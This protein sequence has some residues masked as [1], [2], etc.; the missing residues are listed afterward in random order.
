MRNRGDI[1]FTGIVSNSSGVFV[2]DQRDRISIVVKPGDRAP[3]GGSFDSAGGG[4]T[5]QGGDIAFGAHLA[6]E[7]PFLNSIYVKKAGTGTITSIAHAGEPAPR[8]G[9]FLS[10]YQHFMND[11]GDVPFL[12]LL[13]GNP[14]GI[15]ET[16][17]VYLR[18]GNT[19]TAIARPGD[20][21][22]GGG[23]FVTASFA[24]G[25]NLHL[26]NAN[27]VVFNAKLDTD[28]NHDGIPDTGLYA[29]SHGSLRLIARSGTVI[30]GLGTIAELKMGPST[31][32]PE[33]S[34]VP[35]SGAVNNDRGQV[36]FAAK[37]TD[38]RLVLLLAAPH[39]GD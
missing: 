20:S 23:K 17:G 16:M 19:T 12:G 5:N 35:D 4:L 27:E 26:N 25:G 3:G 11:S 8:G 15:F 32:P 38:N 37:F 29:W 28:D 7:A 2:A 13:A 1:V 18:S 31:V 21:M 10:A 14:N 39:G 6:G 24:L 22:P 33:P 36:V 30:P 9:T 34:Y